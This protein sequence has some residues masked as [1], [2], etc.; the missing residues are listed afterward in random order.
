MIYTYGIIDSSSS[1]I[2]QIT[3]LEGGCVYNLPYRNIGAVISKFINQIK[4]IN[5]DDILKH[6][7]VVERL[8]GNFT[9]L[10]VRFLTTFNQEEEVLG[11]LKEYYQDFKENLSKLRN[12]VE[13]GI[14]VIWPAETIRSR[15]IEASKESNAEVTTQGNSLG[16]SFAKE[17]FQKYK[18]DKEFAEEADRCVALLDDFFSRNAC[19]KKVEKLKS[20]NLLLN[21][22]Y[23]VEKEKQD[24]FKDAFK[25]AKNT[26][27]DL[28]Y[29]FSGP[30]PPY[31]FIN[32]TKKPY[33][34]K[35]FIEGLRLLEKETDTQ[36]LTDK[37]ST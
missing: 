22:Y 3:G 20:D 9:V 24:D 26:P 11:M 34:F 5:K 19:E 31:N 29:L 12:K 17:K 25:R 30:W 2:E 35:D 1:T 33:C 4:E 36:N 14:K 28:K 16:K 6:Q 23:L 37:A 18:I 32:L 21:A 15:I 10:P 8:M 7:E 27:G 13:F